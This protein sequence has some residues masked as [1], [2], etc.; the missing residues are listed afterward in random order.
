MI[1]GVN[2][3]ILPPSPTPQATGGGM[4][5]EH[6]AE[7]MKN[8]TSKVFPPNFSKAGRMIFQENIHHCG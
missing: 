5:F 4:I 6:L 2:F 3:K 7:K 8:W 1:T